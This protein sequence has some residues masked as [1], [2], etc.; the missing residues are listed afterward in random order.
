MNKSFYCVEKMNNY[1]D[2]SMK[3]QLCFLLTTQ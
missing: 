2:R 1:S 3:T